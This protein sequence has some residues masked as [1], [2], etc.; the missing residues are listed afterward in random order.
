MIKIIIKTMTLFSIMA[1][2]ASPVL[3]LGQ[4]EIDLSTATVQDL[5]RALEAGTLTSEELVRRYLARIEA[6]NENGPALKAIISVADNALERARELD[7][8][9]ATRGLAH[10]CMAFLSL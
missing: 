9:R 2:G 7:R 4:H 10:H 6:Y 1:L 5:N 8:E 3:V